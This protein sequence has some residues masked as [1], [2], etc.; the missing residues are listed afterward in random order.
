MAMKGSRPLTDEEISVVSK[1]FS[2]K[3][4]TRDKALFTLGVTS[5]FRVSELLSIQV[6]DVYQHGR[7][8]DRVTVQRRNMK[9]KVE[10]RTVRF[11]PQAQAATAAWLAEACL[12]PNDYLF[13]SHQ[14]GPMTSRQAWNVLDAAFDANGLTGQLGTHTMRKS[15]AGKVYEHFGHDLVKTQ[16][17][18]GHKNVNST[19]SYLSFKDE[20]LDEAVLAIAL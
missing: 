12:Q 17:A 8:T 14:G 1:S 5:G 18:L 6:R 19:V 20:E 2:G 13:Q 10:G 3:Y 15:Y 11:H 9:R 4:A 16:K 7:M